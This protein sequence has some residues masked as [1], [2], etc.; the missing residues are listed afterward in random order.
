MRRIMEAY[1]RDSETF[2][3]LLVPSWIAISLIE[4]FRSMSINFDLNRHRQL[5]G[6]R[7]DE[8]LVFYSCVTPGQI[9]TEFSKVSFYLYAD[10]V[11]L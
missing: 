8:S 4:A 5:V 11:Q 3:R 10:D 1:Y 6:S 9:I 2:W 7:R